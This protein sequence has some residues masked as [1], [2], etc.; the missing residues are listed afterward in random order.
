MTRSKSDRD[1]IDK[2]NQKLKQKTGIVRKKALKDEFD[3]RAEELQRLKA[4]NLQLQAQHE[5]LLN[6]IKEAR[7]EEQKM[8][9]E[10]WY[11]IYK[12]SLVC[13]KHC[14]IEIFSLYLSA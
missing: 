5:D 8:N 10:M 4:E 9:Y 11:I 12:L 2:E 6:V 7:L 1:A 3:N 13:P 14:K